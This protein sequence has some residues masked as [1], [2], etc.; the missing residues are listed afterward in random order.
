MLPFIISC[1][2]INFSP[3]VLQDD[4]IQSALQS[5]VVSPKLSPNLKDRF[6]DLLALVEDL[7]PTSSDCHSQIS[8]SLSRCNSSVHINGDVYKS[9][10]RKNSSDRIKPT[11]HGG[12]KGGHSLRN[13]DSRRAAEAE[14]RQV[15]STYSSNSTSSKR[16][17]RSDSQ[18]NNFDGDSDGNEVGSVTSDSSSCSSEEEEST[19][20]RKTRSGAM[21][22]VD[23]STNK[24]K[25]SGGKRV[26]SEVAVSKDRKS[27][28]KRSTSRQEVDDESVKSE[29]D[30][31]D[32]Y[33]DRV[34]EVV[35]IDDESGDDSNSSRA[36]TS[37]GNN[38]S[39]NN[40]NDEVDDDCRIR[41]SKR[42]KTTIKRFM[43]D[44]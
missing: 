27:T 24:L 5:L 2:L 41:P 28:N 14:R 38:N 15:V 21:R 44:D 32:E 10:V 20:S 12:S 31:D 36:T 3:Q 35:V 16:H 29:D 13:L 17:N 8:D 34:L 26:N 7:P 1:F 43:L 42:R 4:D 6:S 11:S 37:R 9:D 22:S 23:K 19:I 25:T 39:N 30:E 40:D 33:E 18:L